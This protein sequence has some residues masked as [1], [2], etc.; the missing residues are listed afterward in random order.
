MG[1][2]SMQETELCCDSWTTLHSTCASSDAHSR[3]FRFLRG[4]RETHSHKAEVFA[5]LHTRRRREGEREA[6]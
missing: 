6:Q 5:V 3:S 2:E 4:G 1:S